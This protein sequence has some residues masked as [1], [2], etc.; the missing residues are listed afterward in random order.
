[1]K[2]DTVQGTHDKDELLHPSLQENRNDNAIIQ[3]NSLT[4]EKKAKQATQ[5]RFTFESLIPRKNSSNTASMRRADM[6]R[7]T[8]D[9]MSSLS[10]ESRVGTE[11]YNDIPAEAPIERSIPNGRS[12]KITKRKLPSSFCDAVPLSKQ[13]VGV[14]RTAKATEQVTSTKRS[15]H[16]AFKPRRMDKNIGFANDGEHGNENEK[17]PHHTNSQSNSD[18]YNQ[19]RNTP[20]LSSIYKRTSHNECFL[21][22]ASCVG[23]YGNHDEFFFKTIRL[24]FGISETAEYSYHYIHNALWTFDKTENGISEYG[25]AYVSIPDLKRRIEFEEFARNQYMKHSD[26]RLKFSRPNDKHIFFLIPRFSIL[27]NLIICN[28]PAFKDKDPQIVSKWSALIYAMNFD[29]F[30]FLSSLASN[31][32]ISFHNL[33]KETNMMYDFEQERLNKLKASRR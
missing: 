1:M 9:D 11:K 14:A 27:F 25:V 4:I 33:S 29:H 3:K 32:Q 12:E 6:W 21:A 23:F 15:H 7:E 8:N 17:K 26:R 24:V 5:S 20:Q 18:G 2:D 28:V 31:T 10:S 13:Y 16:D 22:K 30:C 19:S